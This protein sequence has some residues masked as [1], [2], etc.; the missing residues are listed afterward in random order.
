MS[1]QQYQEFRTLSSYS[2]LFSQSH[3]I[4]KSVRKWSRTQ[5]DCFRIVFAKRKISDLEEIQVADF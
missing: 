4:A 2:Y 1:S 3:K 5:T